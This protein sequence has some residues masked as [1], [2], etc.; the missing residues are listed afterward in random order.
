MSPT[1]SRVLLRLGLIFGMILLGGVLMWGLAG[2]G[3]SSSIPERQ[4]EL[5]S[6]EQITT[7]LE[8]RGLQVF[9]LER[10]GGLYVAEVGSAE[11]R[12]RLHLDGQTGAVIGMPQVTGPA[13][14]LDELR[15]KLRAE[16]YRE[17]GPITWERGSYQTV[18]TGPEGIRYLLQLETYSG[19]VLERT[20]Q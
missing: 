15:R 1:A 19:E 9:E 20:P 18:A 8:T 4:S 17:I 7:Q 3:P 5:L 16:G 6:E 12:Q 2:V 11:G 14:P 13:L 10:D